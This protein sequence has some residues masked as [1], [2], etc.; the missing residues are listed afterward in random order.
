VSTP[1]QTVSA[2][3]GVEIE[4][5]EA[6]LRVTVPEPGTVACELAVNGRRVRLRFPAGGD[7]DVDVQPAS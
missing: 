4:G 7:V 5:A 6:D 2:T 1:I 3:T